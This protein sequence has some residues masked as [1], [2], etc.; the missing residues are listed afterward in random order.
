MR[1]PKH[2][3]TLIEVVVAM[4]ILA[5]AFASLITNAGNT[6][7]NASYLRD[8]A[9]GL[10]VAENHLIDLQTSPDWVRIGTQKGEMD[11]AGHSW[12]WRAIVEKVANEEAQQYL[13]AVTIEV[14]NQPDQESP[15]AVL[16]GFVG[17]PRI[18]PN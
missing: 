7:S 2:G 5:V 15:S 10:W 9:I 3:F 17:N 11:M 18:S 8:R 6:A 4:A 16:H 12:H 14:R 1:T 13:R